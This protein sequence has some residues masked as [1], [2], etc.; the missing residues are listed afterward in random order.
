[1]RFLLSLNNYSIFENPSVPSEIKL[2]HELKERKYNLFMDKTIAHTF[3]SI[4][5]K[6]DVI[7]R[8]A[9]NQERVWTETTRNGT[10]AHFIT[11]MHKHP[12][13]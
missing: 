9:L 2:D 11:R 7:R 5:S 6:I 13:L 12:F 1:M 8:L 10:V 3:I 4:I